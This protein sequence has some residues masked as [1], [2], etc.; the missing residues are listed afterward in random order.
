MNLTVQIPDD[1]AQS[2]S[3]AG[4][5]MSRRVLE[6]LALDEFQSGRFTKAQLREA[7]GFETS[8]ELD[9]FLKTHQVW[10]EY[11]EEDLERER[12]SLDRLGL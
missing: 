11:G 4:G 3:A 9:G 7:L 10:I 5:D 2:L 12:A 1:L 8:Y 6:A